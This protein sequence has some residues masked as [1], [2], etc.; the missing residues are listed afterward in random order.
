LGGF[1]KPGKGVH[2]VKV[3]VGSRGGASRRPIGHSANEHRPGR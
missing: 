1:G 3:S 2:V